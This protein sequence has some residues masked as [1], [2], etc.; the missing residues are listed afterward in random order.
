MNNRLMMLIAADAVVCFLQPGAAD[1]I[2]EARLAGHAVQRVADGV[3]SQ[4]TLR[5]GGDVALT[6]P[7]LATR[8]DTGIAEAAESA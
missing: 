5:C 1:G 7:R 2:P 3:E 8:I 4:V 6:G